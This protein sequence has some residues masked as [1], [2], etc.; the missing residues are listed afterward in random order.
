[1]GLFNDLFKK[2]T[3]ET[4]TSAQT[5][6]E[7]EFL[8][9]GDEQT[10]L[11][12][13]AMDMYNCYMS[14]D[15]NTFESIANRLIHDIVDEPLF[16]ECKQPYLLGRS[17]FLWM[18][19]HKV[20]LEHTIYGIIV[21]VI[22]ACLLRNRRDIEKGYEQL[23][24]GK[25]I[26]VSKMLCVLYDRY[27]EYFLMKLCSKL[28]NASADIVVHQFW[29]LELVSYMQI[30]ENEKFRVFLDNKTEML[31]KA[32]ESNNKHIINSLPKSNEDKRKLLDHVHENEDVLIEDYLFFKF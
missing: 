3:A 18:I 22:H 30:K 20:D 27:H 31:F 28:P 25:L 9:I 29:G 17:L 23:H 15:I 21:N 19:N 7:S 16:R 13:M 2:F 32:F 8:I 12:K 1:M 4:Q 10:N 6:K 26:S 11:D 24:K 5:H 14:G